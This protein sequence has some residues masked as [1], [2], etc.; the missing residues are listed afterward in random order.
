M[1]K[2]LKE[3][4][5]E[6]RNLLP[7]LKTLYEKQSEVDL[8]LVT[9][10]KEVILCHSVVAAANSYNIKLR[11][12]T[13]DH[14]EHP[15]TDNNAKYCLPLNDVKKT[16]LS[17]IVDY[18]YTGKIEITTDDVADMLLAATILNIRFIKEKAKEVIKKLLC[19]ENYST[20]LQFSMEN[21]LVW[22][23]K[24]I[25]Y[26]FMVAKFP[27][28]LATNEISNLDV[29]MVIGIISDVGWRLENEDMSLDAIMQWLENHPEGVTTDMV[30]RLVECAPFEDCTS[31]K[32]YEVLDKCQA[33]FASAEKVLY[34]KCL[35]HLLSENREHRVERDKKA[36]RE[37]RKTSGTTQ[38]QH[39]QV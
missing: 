39:Q 15:V 23:L 4:V 28:L 34:R 2:H 37:Q 7:S 5:E 30:E 25:C 32:V 33:L 8:A 13:Y 18:F 6:E 22:D 24:F 38:R 31:Q 26:D 17:R 19:M 20:F 10:D 21:V 35:L 36:K 11:L 16:P 1:S 9:E 27:E 14:D 3:R 29:D 12:Q